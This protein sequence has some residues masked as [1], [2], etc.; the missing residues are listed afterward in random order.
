L[1][2]SAYQE[3]KEAEEKRIKKMEEQIQFLLETQKEILECQKYPEKFSPS[4][5]AVKH[6]IDEIADEQNKLWDSYHE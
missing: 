3:I 2:P 5:K 4:W 6:T 1:V